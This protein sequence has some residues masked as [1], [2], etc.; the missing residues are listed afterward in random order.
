METLCQDFHYGFRMLRKSPGFTAV[1]ILT[2]ALGMGANTTIFSVLNAVLLRPLPFPDSSRLALLYEGFP[3]LGFSKFGFSAPDL[4]EYQKA[5]KSFQGLAAFQNKDFELSGAGEPQRITA[6]RVTANLFSVLGVAPLLGRSFTADEDQPGHALA[7]ISYGLWQSKF[8]KADEVIGRTINLDRQPYT[9]I[10]VMP[11]GFQFPLRGP[12]IN[13][14][15][16]ALYLPMAY[17]RDELGGWGMRYN[18]SVVGRLRPGVSLEQA[19]TE[20]HLLSERIKQEYPADL[21]KQFGS[22][23]LAMPVQSM[24]QEV[25][26][27]VRPLLVVLQAAVAV[28]LLIACVNVGLLL[29]SRASARRREIAVRAALGAVRGRLLR[30]LMAECLALSLP[31]GVLGLCIAIVSKS[32]LLKQLPAGIPLPAQ[33][34]TDAAV[35]GFSVLT[36]LATVLIFGLV[37]AFATSRVDLQ[38]SLQEGG[39]SGTSG[40]ARHRLQSVFVIV[41]FVLALTL[42]ISAGLLLRSFGKLLAANPG[43]HPEGILTM[44]VPLPGQAYPHAQDL[45]NYYQ[46]AVSE[47]S[48]LPG[49]VS[50]SASTAVPLA[51]GGD[52]AALSVEGRSELGDA[53]S[54]RVVEFLGDY[55]KTLGIPLLRGRTITDD[56]RANTQPV[57]LISESMARKLW[58]HEEALGKRIRVETADWLTVVGIVGDVHDV[59]LS[60]EPMLMVYKSYRQVSDEI[61]ADTVTGSRRALSLS[62]RTMGDPSALANAALAGIHRLD[63]ALAVVNVRTMRSEVQTSVAPQRFSA[64][65][66]AIYAGLALL[67]AIVGIYGVLAHIVSQQRSEIGIRMAL[68]AQRKDVLAM[69]LRRGAMLALIGSVLGLATAWAASRMVA[70]LLYGISPRDPVTFLTVTLLLVLAALAACYLPARRAAKVDPMVALRY[71]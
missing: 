59:S 66:L 36:M 58:P 7:V 25:V 52:I 20:A 28:V 40:R 17:T 47:L 14:H 24:R 27:E 55:L 63:P 48:G 61:V 67:L 19:R 45:R 15:E 5:Q 9:I 21:M 68:G 49:V 53:T 70:S 57:V 23:T 29:L 56:D 46:Q 71:E 41:E 38:G 65:L 62:V 2:L 35:L 33:A 8:G 6:A 26:G 69:V 1:A 3:T 18:N 60:A 10:G 13:N 11:A 50:A 22:P 51:A 32:V 37:P 43:F 16:A 30:Q 44:T 31:A 4:L 42:M 39:R 54:V 12:S 64:T 34:T